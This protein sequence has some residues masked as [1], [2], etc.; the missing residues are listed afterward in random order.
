M[1]TF[2]KRLKTLREDRGLSI[3]ELGEELNIDKSSLHRW[4]TGRVM[5]KGDVLLILADFFEVSVD[6]LLGAEE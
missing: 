6:Y 5:A 4:E 3:R 2:H 1:S